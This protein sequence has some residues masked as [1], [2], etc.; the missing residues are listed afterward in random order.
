M[1]NSMDI[2]IAWG[3]YYASRAEDSGEISIFRLLDFDTYAYQAA[4]FEETFTNVPQLETLAKLS[5]FVAHAPIDSR[6]LLSRGEVTLIGS[7]PLNRE[8]LEGYI[9]YLEVHEVSKK[10]IDKLITEVIA[11]SREPMVSFRLEII[12]NELVVSEKK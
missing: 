4:L 7:E 6:R 1:K 2:D 11:F 5:P 10:D 8:D 9:S 12:N 3:G